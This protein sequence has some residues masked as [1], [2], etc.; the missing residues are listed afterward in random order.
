MSSS[1][2]ML[3]LFFHYRCV[4][5]ELIFAETENWNWKHCS[6]IIFKCVNSAVG[7]IL[8]K[9]VAEKCNLW[10]REQCTNALFTVDKVF[11][12]QCFRALFTNPQITLFSNFFIKNG[13]HSTIYTFKNYFA[14]VFSVLVKIS[15]IQTYPSCV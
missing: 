1:H 7:P 8:N 4:W 6:E 13:S 14:T 10:D 11:R 9:K 5:I 3:F 2:S 12:E 15:S